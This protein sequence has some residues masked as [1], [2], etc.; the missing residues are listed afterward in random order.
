MFLS[1]PTVLQET[2]CLQIKYY[3][4][5]P[6]DGHPLFITRIGIP[7]CSQDQGTADLNSFPK[8]QNK[9]TTCLGRD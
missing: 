1:E 9:E 5:F 2:K 8:T 6:Q 3:V 4:R 7:I